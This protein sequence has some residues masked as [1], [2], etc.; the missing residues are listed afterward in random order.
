[1]SIKLS[2]IINV[3]NAKDYKVHL[4]N[5]NGH[6]QPL[7]IFVSDKDRWKGWNSWRGEKDDFNRRY[8]FSLIDY[9]HE[10]NIWL[11]GGVYEVTKRLNVARAKGYE[12]E[13]TDQFSHFVGRLKIRWSRSGRAK[14][15]R[16]ENYIDEYEVSEILKEVYTGEVFCGYERINHDFHVL[17]SIFLSAKPDWKGALINV[18]GVYLIVDKQNGKKYVGSAYG[19]SGIWSRW[20]CY[21]GNG[22]GGYSDE[23]TKLIKQ[24]GID[25]ARKNFRFSLLEYRPMKTDDTEVIRRE[26]YWKEA[27]LSRGEFGYNAN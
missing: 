27:L 8:I 9:Y 6:N 1:M 14:S 3:E 12:V 18:K 20:L 25:Y 21:M 15:R 4:A 24:K 5:W 19:G 11:F 22:H 16:L 2:E 26:N 23:L 7:D 10:P 17:E 13:L